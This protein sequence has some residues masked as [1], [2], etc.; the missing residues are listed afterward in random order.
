MKKIESENILLRKFQTEDAEEAFKNWAGIKE[1][2]DLSDYRVHTSA[3]ETKQ[4][5]EIGLGDG[6]GE[7]YT[8]AIIFKGTEEVAGFIRIYDISSKNKTCKIEFVVGKSWVN[9]G[10]EK[11]YAEAINDIV[12][13]L[14]EKGFDVISY[15]CCDGSELYKI[16]EKVLEYTDFEKE[17]QAKGEYE[18]YIN[19]LGNKLSRLTSVI[20]SIYEEVSVLKETYALTDD[21]IK[22]LDL[23]SKELTEEKDSFKSIND[24]TLTR[25]TPYSRLSKDCE[26]ISVRISKTEDKL[27]SIMKSLGSLKEDELRAR[28]QLTEIRTIL[29]DAKNKIKSYKLPVIPKNYFIELKEAKE[30][31]SLVIEELEKKPIVINDLNTRVDTGRDLVLKLYTL[32]NELTKTAGMAEMAIVYGNRYRSTYKEIE[33]SLIKAEKE[34]RNGDYKKSLETSL[35]ALNMVEPGIHKRLMSAY[36]S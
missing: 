10:K 32:T 33:F 13:H 14:F 28:D 1:I 18:Y 4:M 30:G 27:E 15:E 11:L 17:K 7:R 12:F 35:N 31:V 23:I 29:K 3:E 8:L 26:L 16:N 2:A 22:S 20:K 5:I 6:K 24:R 25:T 34:F 19:N 36:E 9:A 21:E